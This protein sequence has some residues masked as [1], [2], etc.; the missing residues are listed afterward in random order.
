[1]LCCR[2]KNVYLFVCFCFL[3][4]SSQ[5]MPRKIFWKFHKYWTWFRWDSADPKICLFVFLVCLLFLFFV[6]LFL[7]FSFESCQDTPRNIFW[8]FHKYLT[9]YCWS[10]FLICLFGFF[11]TSFLCRFCNLRI[12]SCSLTNDCK[13]IVIWKLFIFAKF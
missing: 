4:E 2:S 8:K 11:R 6:G 1:M 9:L 13:I 3:F 10:L 5:D 12:N 7:F